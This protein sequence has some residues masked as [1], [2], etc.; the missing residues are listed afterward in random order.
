MTP[1]QLAPALEL[2]AVD[3]E[4]IDAIID[5]HYERYGTAVKGDLH[6][7][8][9]LGGKMAREREVPAAQATRG[10]VVPKNN[11]QKCPKCD[12][13]GIVS[14]PPWVAGDV[15][16]WSSTATSWTC[17]VCNGAKILLVPDKTPNAKPTGG[18]AVRVE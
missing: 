3:R 11:Y 13:Q 12:G 17:D 8:L 10:L 7:M 2:T 15:R 9:F 16:E 5:G 4:M 1:E 6:G 18:A 14:K